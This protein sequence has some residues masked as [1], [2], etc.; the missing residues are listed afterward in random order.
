MGQ[1]HPQPTRNLFWATVS[2][3]IGLVSSPVVA[4]PLIIERVVAVVDG[5]VISAQDLRDEAPFIVGSQGAEPSIP[6]DREAIMRVLDTMIALRLYA[7][8]ADE[9]GSPVSISTVDRQI[10]RLGPGSSVEEQ[11]TSLG[12]RYDAYKSHLLRQLK[13]AY[14]KE[15]VIGARVVISTAQVDQCARGRQPQGPEGDGWGEAR[16]LCERELRVEAIEL[17]SAELLEELRGLYPIQVRVV[18]DRPS[19]RGEVTP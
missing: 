16:A 2:V 14:V 12:L 13:A 8:H 5:E 6:E 19:G 15:T 1:R 18:A 7:R 10:E 11:I 9:L 3:A 17:G 4:E